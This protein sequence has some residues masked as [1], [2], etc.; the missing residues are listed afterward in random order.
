MG[1]V[2]QLNR[3][4]LKKIGIY[5]CLSLML[6]L[7]VMSMFSGS[8]AYAEED[9]QPPLNINADASILIEAS[10]GQVLYQNNANIALP[11]ASMAKM[12]TEYLVL[13]S[14]EQGKI[15]W[16]ES[17]TISSKAAAIPGSGQLLAEGETYTVRDMFRYMAIYSGNDGAVALA[18]KVAG[19]EENFV[20]MMNQKAKEMGMSNT[21]FFANATGL[22]NKDLGDLAP[23]TAE[24]IIS[25][26]DLATLARRIV[27]DFPE[28]L[29]VSSTPTAYL[30]EGDSSTHEFDNWNWMLEGW[31]SYNNNFSSIAYE[32]L[33]GLKTG[34]TT[35]AGYCFTGTAERDGIRLISV[36]MNT[37]SRTAR[38]EETGRLLDYGFNNFEIKT[39]V[40]A[41]SELDDI[42]TVPVKKGI[43][44]E[45][46]IQTE[47][48][49]ELVVEKGESMDNIQF[50]T[51]ILPEEELIA[52][53]QQ[54][55]V[56]G[57]LTV[58]YDQLSE[59]FEET[60]NL[61]AAEDVEKAS[62]FRLLLRAIKDFFVDIFE[63]IKG[64]F[65]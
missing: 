55:D 60:L 49:V 59:P 58:K 23:S 30:R 21:A 31:K 45:V 1:E 63:G 54:G 27:L 32:G 48:G 8:A 44:L 10:T 64:F 15:S 33:D 9:T 62:W 36:V 28:T 52:P 47:A 42:K 25:A 39:V 6:N 37:E 20:N 53:I 16:D 43:E 57:T 2:T 3:Y 65:G 14:I 11:P 4:V 26:Q 61:V 24:T 19:S 41:K 38:F 22:P 56:I 29:K 5:L 46:P 51:T 12:M 40:A 7:F 34:S 17:V 50:E 13:E 35:E 18:E